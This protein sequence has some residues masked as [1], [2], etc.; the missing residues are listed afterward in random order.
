MKNR[1]EAFVVVGLTARV[2]VSEPLASRKASISGAGA[3]SD[4]KQ[5]FFVWWGEE[6]E[7]AGK[8]KTEKF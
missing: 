7:L 5:G 3:I 6:G 1:A 2:M 4:V 8:N